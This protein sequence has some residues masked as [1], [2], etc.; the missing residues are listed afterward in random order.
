MTY[1]LHA[2]AIPV[3]PC[4]NL[5]ETVAFYGR[6]GFELIF[7]QEEP[8]PYAILGWGEVELHFFG[9]DGLDPATSVAR[10]YLR[11]DDADVVYRSWR[12][13]DLPEAGLPRIAEIADRPWGMREFEVLDPD[14]NCVRVGHI[15]E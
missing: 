3:L 12:T 14:G 2:T 11:V 4:R 7:E 1:R 13:L 6:L 9:H 8:D 10:C 5:D 15:L